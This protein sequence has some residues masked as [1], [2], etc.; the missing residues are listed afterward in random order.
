MIHV[1]CSH[2]VH[3]TFSV[4][5][6]SCTLLLSLTHSVQVVQSRNKTQLL[7]YSKWNP[8]PY[9]AYI[10]LHSQSSLLCIFLHTLTG[11]SFSCAFLP[12]TMFCEVY[13]TLF[14]LYMN[15][16]SYEI[17]LRI[18]RIMR[19]HYCSHF[20]EWEFRLES[21]LLAAWHCVQTVL[22][23]SVLGPSVCHAD[24][25]TSA[26]TLQPRLEST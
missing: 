4:F 2:D 10:I 14:L 8:P 17:I 6:M 11:T 1:W 16:L 12:S 22:C 7:D 18:I 25:Y 3:V 26:I 5:G 13:Y 15:V 19:S 23:H 20:P 24:I 9:T 21:T